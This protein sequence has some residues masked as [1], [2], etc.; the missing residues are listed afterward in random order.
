MATTYRVLESEMTEIADAIRGLTGESEKLSFPDGMKNAFIN[1]PV[2]TNREEYN[3]FVGIDD[4][5]AI[6]AGRYVKADQVLKPLVPKEIQLRFR[7]EGSVNLPS[8]NGYAVA[9]CV[10][11]EMATMPSKISAIEGISAVTPV[12]QQE[13]APNAYVADAALADLYTLAAE[14]NSIIGKIKVL[15]GAGSGGVSA[16]FRFDATLKYFE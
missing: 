13:W 15:I 3:S 16:Y 5:T 7:T 1:M 11:D 8:A 2:V 6:Q 4:K 12:S 10:V 14:N 9:T